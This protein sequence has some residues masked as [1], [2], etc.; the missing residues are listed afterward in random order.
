[1]SRYSGEGVSV[2]KA[3]G[4]LCL[5]QVRCLQTWRLSLAKRRKP[6]VVMVMTSNNLCEQR[7]TQSYFD[8]NP[9]CLSPNLLYGGLCD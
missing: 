7:L 3:M 9:P 5:L 4:K 2:F 6:F 1:M 8:G